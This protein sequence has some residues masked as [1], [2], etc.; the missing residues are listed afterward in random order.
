[1][2]E[3]ASK[4]DPSVRTDQGSVVRSLANVKNDGGVIA[5]QILAVEKAPYICYKDPD[6]EIAFLEV[7]DT[8]WSFQ[9][10]INSELN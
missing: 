7:P 1:M 10:I 8:K 6:G 3:A 9:Q 2:L 5:T 4:V